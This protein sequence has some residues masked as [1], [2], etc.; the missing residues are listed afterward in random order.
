MTTISTI[1]GCGIEMNGG[2]GWGVFYI[3]LVFD[4]VS[5]FDQFDGFILRKSLPD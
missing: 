1:D 3:F 5:L 2:E 4:Y